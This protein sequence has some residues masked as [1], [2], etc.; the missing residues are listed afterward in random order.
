[1]VEIV[2]RHELGLRPEDPSRLSQRPAGAL[3]GVTVHVTVTGASDPVG[4]WRRIQAEYLDGTNVNHQRYGDLPYNDAV[5]MDG[6]ILE[7]RAHHWTGAHALSAGNI[8]NVH[9]LGVAVI[10][11]GAGI[12]QPAKRALRAYVYLAG[13]ELHRPPALFDHFDWAAFGGIATRCP[14]PPIAAFVGQLR[15]EQRRP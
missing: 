11:T 15:A 1:M 4:T 12:S 3:L 10:G 13:L 7:G 5:T 6:R 2:R 8:A 9:T 14:D